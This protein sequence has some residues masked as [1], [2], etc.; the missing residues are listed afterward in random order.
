MRNR[1][2]LFSSFLFL[3]AVVSCENPIKDVQLKF[4]E[5]I[6]VALLELRVLNYKYKVP[7]NVNIEI[8]GRNK[9]A[10]VNTLNIRKFRLNSEGTVV[11][12][13][14]P[15]RV[16]KTS[17]PIA[18]SIILSA[19]GYISA[20][21][22]VK[23]TSKNNQS[24]TIFLGLENEV[25]NN[26]VVGNI[27]TINTTGQQIKSFSLNK[28]T[29]SEINIP[30]G[31]NANTI[32][33][34]PLNIKETQL[35]ILAFDN[36]KKTFLPTDGLAQN[37][38][39]DSGQ[40]LSNPFKINTL[41]GFANIQIFDKTGQ[42]G[43]SFSK[44]LVLRIYLNSNTINPR[45]GKAIKLNDQI[46]IF[47]YDDYTKTWTKYSSEKILTEN[48]QFYVQLSPSF[49][50]VWIA[51][52]AS[53]LCSEGP[54]FQ[55][56]SPYANVDINYLYQILDNTSNTILREFY[57]PINT[58]TNYTIRNIEFSENKLKL[59]IL[60]KSDFRGG[61]S[62][63]LAESKALNTCEKSTN[64]MDLM[65]LKIAD[66]IKVKFEVKCPNGEILDEKLIPLEMRTQ[67]RISGEEN[68]KYLGT[69]TRSTREIESYKLILKSTYDFRLSTDGG[70]TW[71][72]MESNFKVNVK[73][74]KIEIDASGYCK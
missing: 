43:Y 4:K 72:F 10:V 51:A 6:Q 53:D 22:P 47:R 29:I 19:P 2:I 60:N 18:Y 5:P 64:A 37:P 31:F 21:I 38:V 52:W 34:D 24:K 40:K 62:K 17:E 20:V 33:G 39:N 9:D 46:E 50:G 69:F 63:I 16:P 44:P 7:D 54:T 30:A 13:I 35:S 61:D 26:Q 15:E 68:W 11:F 67:I 36:T 32:D 65:A 45:T 14:N 70:V 3:G 74:W 8:L 73:N 55:I 66:P 49:A 48:S 25:E 56:K 57:W 23:F 1:C 12:A 42:V 71:P 59:R 41:G 27:E 28:S 58:S